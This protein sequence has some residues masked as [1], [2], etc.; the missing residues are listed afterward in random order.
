MGMSGT[1]IMMAIMGVTAMLSSCSGGTTDYYGN[2]DDSSKFLQPRC[3][4]AWTQTSCDQGGNQVFCWDTQNERR[5]LFKG[6]TVWEYEDEKRDEYS[7]AGGIV[8]AP[9]FD[10]VSYG[11][12]RKRIDRTQQVEIELC[13]YRRFTQPTMLDWS[14]SQLLHVPE[15]NFAGRNH[16]TLSLS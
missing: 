5:N 4:S 7:I 11:I 13:F 1:L 2:N 8:G 6:T 3:C 14:P 12:S 15:D 9:K 16:S 10:A